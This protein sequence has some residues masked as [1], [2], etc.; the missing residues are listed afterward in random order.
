MEMTLPEPRWAVP[1]LFTEGL[2]ILA[3]KPKIGKSWLSL[4]I[5]HAVASGREIF[6]KKVEIG[7]VLYLALE[8]TLRR[9]QD[10][11]RKL[12]G[13]AHVPD[14]LHFAH[15]WERLKSGGQESLER[16]TGSH[17][18]CRL[19][20]IDTLTRIRPPRIRGADAYEEDS[21]LGS[22]LQAFGHRHHLAVV[23]VHH[24]R[25]A[26]GSDIIDTVH[27]STG[28][29]GAAD[30]IAV[31]T[32][33]RGAGEGLLSITGRDIDEEQIKLGFDERSC[34]WT[35]SESDGA[36]VLS[37]ERRAILDLL[38][39]TERPLSP[40]EIAD[41]CGLSH[42]SVKHLVRYLAIDKFIVSHEDGTYSLGGKY[43]C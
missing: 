7:E 10:R 29:T 37:T 15:E 34:E 11:L 17:P 40:K 4:A 25:K 31:L 6:G 26:K 8:D 2:N 35:L 39:K 36:P 3:G 33:N 19:I 21:S 12:H 9:L 38:S 32:R 5:A 14:G 18:D 20:I 16:W 13:G 28:L 1:G 42:G 41:A 24:T 27:G 43:G 23:V 22:M 30:S